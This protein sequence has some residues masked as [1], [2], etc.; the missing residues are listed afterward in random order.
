MAE[1][2]RSAPGYAGGDFRLALKT[3]FAAVDAALCSHAGREDMKQLAMNTQ[4]SG[5]VAAAIARA[6]VRR[7]S[8]CHRC[9]VLHLLTCTSTGQ[10]QPVALRRR[11]GR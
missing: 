7:H 8:P 2:V 10:G 11:P 1:A 5:S 3:A 4:D 6:Q 9:I